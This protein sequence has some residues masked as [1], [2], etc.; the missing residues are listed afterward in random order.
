[1]FIISLTVWTGDVERW[2]DT[3]NSTHSGT[4]PARDIWAT[5]GG[6]TPHWLD[7]ILI[8]AIWQQ[9]TKYAINILKYSTAA[10]GG[11]LLESRSVPDWQL[12]LCGSKKTSLLTFI[13]ADTHLNTSTY[14][15]GHI[16]LLKHVCASKPTRMSAYKFWTACYQTTLT[17]C[18]LSNRMRTVHHMSKLT[19][20]QIF[21][22][23]MPPGDKTSI[24]LEN[25]PVE[26]PSIS[27][28][29]YL[30]HLS[31][32]KAKIWEQTALATVFQLQKQWDVQQHLMWKTLNMPN[33]SDNKRSN[34]I[35]TKPTISTLFLKR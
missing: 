34:A 19:S 24:E 7:R 31:W 30:G 12:C 9:H 35:Y 4:P 25:K 16:H 6:L 17:S 23:I 22:H 18:L 15:H 5:S 29:R 13:T 33:D 2:S 10:C 32:R 26:F 11:D 8:K 1:M 21:S 27:S 28:H 20:V 3:T 14:T